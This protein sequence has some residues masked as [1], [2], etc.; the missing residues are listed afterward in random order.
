[1]KRKILRMERS[2]KS[3]VGAT[4]VNEIKLI[5]HNEKITSLRLSADNY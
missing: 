2:S 4:C 1:M 5:S 3:P